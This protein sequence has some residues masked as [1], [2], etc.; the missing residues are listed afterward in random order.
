MNKLEFMKDNNIAIFVEI[1]L[2]NN[3]MDIKRRY[4]EK[5]ESYDL[6]YDFKEEYEDNYFYAKELNKKIENFYNKNID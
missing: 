2:Q 4:E 6:F 1:D 5:L 3:T